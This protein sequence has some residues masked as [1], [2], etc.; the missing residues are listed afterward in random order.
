MNRVKIGFFSFTEITDPN[1]HH[2]YNEWHQF[3]HMPEQYRIPGIVHGQRWVSTPDCASTRLVAEEPVNATHYITLYLMSDP[4]ESTL[5]SFSDLGYE[6]RSLGRFH[7][8]R[9]AVLVAPHQWL[10]AHAARRVLVHPESIPYRPNKGV[11]VI[12]EEP[13]S[14][15]ALDQLDSWIQNL[16][17]S[18]NDR[19][20]EVP[21]V[22]GIWQFVSNPRLQGPGWNEGTRRITVCWLDDEPVAVA[23]RLEALVRERWQ[24]GT[25]KPVYAG[26]LESIEPFEWDWFNK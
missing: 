11:Y 14:D 23:G 26:P 16:H 15:I 13:N 9:R 17:T 7:A 19:A 24:D 18:W 20:C 12:V 25:M 4:V 5:R 1:E 3:D 2:A 21:G 6:L 10:D 22:A 8:H